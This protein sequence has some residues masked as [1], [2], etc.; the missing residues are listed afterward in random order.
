MTPSN[1]PDIFGPETGDSAEQLPTEYFANLPQEFLNEW[2]PD[3]VANLGWPAET[4][5]QRWMPVLGEHPSQ[6]RLRTWRKLELDLAGADWCNETATTIANLRA[7]CFGSPPTRGWQ[8][9]SAEALRKTTRIAEYARTHLA[10]PGCLMAFRRDDGL[11]LVDGYH[12][13]TWLGIGRSIAG[14]AFP[15][16]AIVSCFDGTLPGLTR[17]L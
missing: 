13:V 1:E 10:L 15:V 17:T 7:T 2:L 11:F 14:S 8:G 4:R 3:R 9:H 6:F 12:R 16:S 5:V